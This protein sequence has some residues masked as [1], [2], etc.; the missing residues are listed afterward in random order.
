MLNSPLFLTSFALIAFAANSVFA[1]LALG[2]NQIDAG[3]FTFIRLFSASLFFIL[4]LFV[5]WQIKKPARPTSRRGDKRARGSSLSAFYLFGY[6]LSFSYAYIQL[7]TAT[8][9]LVLFATVQV[10]MLLIGLVKGR[11]LVLAEW[12]GLIIALI[13]FVVLVAPNLNTPSLSAF[14]LMSLSG[15][16]WALYTLAGKESRD[17][18]C[19]TIF[20]FLR[21]LPLLIPLVWFIHLD[22]HF[23]RL[24]VFYACLSGVFASALGYLI[25]YQALTFLRHSSAAVLQLLVPVL[26]AIAGFVLLGESISLNFIIASLLILGG[27]LLVIKG[28]TLIAGK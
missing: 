3:S 11:V 5:Q 13:G 8:G 14:I 23:T 24:G 20:N 16:C 27:I 7:D 6:A 17:P 12:L 2:D 25:W 15:L 22:M 9:A 19:D 4:I 10:T 18:S 28:P 26:A 21:T 1:R